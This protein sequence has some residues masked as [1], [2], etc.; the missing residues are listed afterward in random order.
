M[1]QEPK[2]QR[3]TWTEKAKSGPVFRGRDLLPNASSTVD[4]ARPL[5][6]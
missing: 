6:D 2:N 3:E 1:D 4:D 5:G